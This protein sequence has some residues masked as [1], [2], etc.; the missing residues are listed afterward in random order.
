MPTNTQEYYS[1]LSVN[2][3]V[4]I[5]QDIYKIKDKNSDNFT[6]S[7]EKI[8]TSESEKK[9][10][11]SYIKYRDAIM[12]KIDID[13][14]FT[15]DNNDIRISKARDE[16]HTVAFDLYGKNGKPIKSVKRF[17]DDPSMGMMLSLIYP[18][19]QPNG[20]FIFKRS[21]ILDERVITNKNIHR[22]EREQEVFYQ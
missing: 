1:S 19:E 15:I 8:E 20:T 10:V 7:L 5:E 2:S 21:K 9:F 12:R 22:D 3:Y 14:D 18:E 17:S 16:V 4:A 13:N 6:I 11:K